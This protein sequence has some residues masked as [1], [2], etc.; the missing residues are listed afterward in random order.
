MKRPLSRKERFRLEESIAAAE[1][2]TDAQIVLVVVEKSD[3]YAE[4]PWKAF[5]LSAAIAGFLIVI[6]DLWYSRW[7]SPA[8][9]MFSVLI[10]LAAGI[11]S[12]LFSIYLPGF[13]RL[14][15]SGHRA[16]TEVRQ[17]AESLFLSRELYATKH[18]KGILLL[19][20]LFEHQIILLPD[21]GLKRRLSPKTMQSIIARMKPALC[22]G[23]VARALEMGLINLV[24][25][26]AVDKRGKV[27]LNELSDSIIEE[28][29]A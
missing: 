10:I 29:G 12:A 9:V 7:C 24:E 27:R 6:F 2:I 15:L 5:A 28:K 14:F 3:A 1:K 8:A 16:E 11:F 18:R 25:V 22:A 23:Q 20:S 4:I 26:L 17:Y 19:I 21:K 13:A